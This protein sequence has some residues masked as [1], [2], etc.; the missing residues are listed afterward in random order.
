MKIT[1]VL[2]IWGQVVVGQTVKLFYSSFP[3]A[4]FPMDKSPYQ[5]L[6]GPYQ[7]SCFPSVNGSASTSLFLFSYIIS[8]IPVHSH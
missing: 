6:Q 7:A 5:A 4:G 2:C 1:A 8:S 3:V